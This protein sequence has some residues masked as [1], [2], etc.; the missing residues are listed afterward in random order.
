MLNI[1][2]KTI[3]GQVADVT[4]GRQQL[5]LVA[6]NAAQRARL[7]G[8]LNNNCFVTHGIHLCL[9]LPSKGVNSILHRYYR[10][11]GAPVP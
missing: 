10:Q 2:R 1:H 3:L 9:F 5:I 8:G 4:L 11:N 7:G 6:Q